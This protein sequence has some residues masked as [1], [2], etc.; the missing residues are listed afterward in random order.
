MSEEN[1]INTGSVLP[2]LPSAEPTTLFRPGL[3]KGRF[4]R[5]QYFWHTLACSVVVMLLYFPELLGEEDF[6]NIV[7]TVA[8]VILSSAV[9]IVWAFP[10]N[11]KRMHDIGWSGWWIL[12]GFIPLVGS[13]ASLVLGLI[14]LFKDSQPGTNEY[15]TSVKYPNVR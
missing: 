6:G 15:G 11:V 7:F 3:Y 14:L 4:T 9:L 13:I 10:V 12:V 1:N 2:Q 5:K 8:W